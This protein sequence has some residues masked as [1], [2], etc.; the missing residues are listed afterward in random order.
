MRRTNETRPSTS[1]STPVAVLL[2]D[3]A[4]L[5]RDVELTDKSA[6]VAERNA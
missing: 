2:L 3:S 6:S 5:E 4:A 1:A